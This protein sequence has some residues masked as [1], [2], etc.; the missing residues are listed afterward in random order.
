VSEAWNNL[1][2]G[3]SMAEWKELKLE[4]EPGPDGVE[5]NKGNRGGLTGSDGTGFTFSVPTPGCT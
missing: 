5:E 3:K 4:R 1:E 2:H